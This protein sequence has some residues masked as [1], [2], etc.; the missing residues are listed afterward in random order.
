MAS[1]SPSTTEPF[2]NYIES[3]NNDDST[4]E[5]RPGWGMAFFAIAACVG[6]LLLAALLPT[7][8]NL[9]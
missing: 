1:E 8:L 5:T 6:Y 3:S 4:E 9:R 7:V 2:K